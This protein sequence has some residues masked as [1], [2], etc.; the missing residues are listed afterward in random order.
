M[1]WTQDSSH[2]FLRLE[3]GEEILNTLNDFARM[4]S[5][6]GAT[7]HGIGALKDVTLSYFNTEK[8]GYEE[9]EYKEEFELLSIIGN[10]SAKGEQMLTHAHVVLG[11][12]DQSTIG[13]H[14][15]KGYVSVTAEMQIHIVHTPL[16]RVFDEETGLHL[17]DLNH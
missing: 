17:L 13:G 6:E 12:A 4:Q 14:L 3:K 2:F 8:R 15:C 1:Q 7:I 16:Q 9:R 5:I 10:I 11:R